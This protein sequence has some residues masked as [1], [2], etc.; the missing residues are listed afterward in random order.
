MLKFF[1]DLL[2]A[3]EEARLTAGEDL[4]SICELDRQLGYSRASRSRGNWGP[5]G[6]R[7]SPFTSRTSDEG[8]GD[9]RPTVARLTEIPNNLT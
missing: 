9:Q 2:K 8:L 7:L 5:A 6:D 3:S 4:Q 1:K